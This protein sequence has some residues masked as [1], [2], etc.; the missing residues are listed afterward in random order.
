M[1]AI[2]VQSAAAL[3]RIEKALAATRNPRGMLL[4]AGR[5]VG[6]RLRG[7]FREKQQREPNRLG[8]KRTNFWLQVMRGVQSPVTRGT[9]GVTVSI[10]HPA[11]AQ[12]VY[13]GRIVPKRAKALTIPVSREA[14]G[15]TAST[16][17]HEKGILLFV[18]GKPDGQKQGVLAEL[19]RTRGIVVHYV[20]MKSVNQ[21]ADATALPS[22]IFLAMGAAERAEA[23]L[24]RELQS[25][26][27]S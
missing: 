22:L 2:T 21:E 25:P 16:L 12:K 15:R 20:L 8:G 1:I 3:T 13:G 9:H 5:E 7:H 14:Y 4:T 23:V 26:R 18:L 19:S 6:N 24:A 27:I 11:I 10:N 17:E